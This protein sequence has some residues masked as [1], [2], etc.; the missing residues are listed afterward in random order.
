MDEFT[1]ER[2]AELVGMPADQV[3]KTLVAV[4]ERNGPCFAVIP[5]N[6][7]LDLK[8]L[9]S[10]HGERKIRL[11][12]LKEVLPLTGYQRGAVTA[13]GA[14][15]PFPVYLDEI[16]EL[17]EEIAVSAGTT[18]AQVVLPTTAYVSL[19]NATIAAIGR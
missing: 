8:A 5:A 6:T 9:A 10:A 7:E 3:F 16:A 15:K 13:I 11:A 2:V 18:G 17:F 1:A 4:G 12:S 19:T 14:K